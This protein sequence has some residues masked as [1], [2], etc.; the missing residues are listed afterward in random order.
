MPLQFPTLA[1]QALDEFRTRPE[2]NSLATIARRFGAT[3]E[4][5]STWPNEIIYTFDDDTSLKTTGR[6]KTHK[7]E[8]LLP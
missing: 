7:V 5:T 6:G 2:G 4:R 1:E 3:V 8:T